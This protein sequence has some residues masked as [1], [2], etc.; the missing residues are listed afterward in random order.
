MMIIMPNVTVNTGCRM[1]DMQLKILFAIA[2]LQ[3]S[4]SKV[5]SEIM[6]ALR[7]IL[8]SFIIQMY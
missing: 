4:K 5:T 1:I 6:T 8:K 3:R 2:F 7:K